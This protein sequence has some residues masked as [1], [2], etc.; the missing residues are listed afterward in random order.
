MKKTA[1]TSKHEALGA[2]MVDFAGYRMPIQYH[3]IRAEHMRVR[4]TVGVFDV[5]HMGEFFVTGEGREEF[6]D[7]MTVN[8]VKSMH[9]G[10]AQYSCMCMPDGGIVDDLLIYKFEDKFMIV[11]NAANTKKDWDWLFSHKPSTVEMKDRTDDYSL[12]AIQGREASAVINQIA[13]S[14]VTSLRYYT[15]VDG[16]A[17]DHPAIISRT[18]YTGE[19]GFELYLENEFAPDVWDAVMK[20]GKRY[21]IE[22]IGLGARDS[23][24][25][26][27]KMAL[28]GNDID[29]TTNPL[30][31]G[32]GWITKLN[33]ES[34]FVGK[35]QLLKIKEEGV[36]RRL[37]AIQLEDSGFPRPGYPILSETKGGEVIGKVTSGTVSPMLNKGIALG[38]VPVDLA[39]VGTKL[40]IDC[41]G[42]INAAE[43]IKPPFYI[44][45]Y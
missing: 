22:P 29:G 43:V 17:C 45:P 14:D 38:Y 23:L 35:E 3:S 11:V 24:R 21:E 41:R 37:A 15:F 36:T 4:T 26:E 8:D 7:R 33:K 20:A 16:K 12:L 10:Q 34:D 5:S 44:R 2:K 32:L 27:M 39:K 1:L 19:D 9:A 28:Y 30:E 25:L 13:D 31:A 42:K 18:G 6:I 40:A